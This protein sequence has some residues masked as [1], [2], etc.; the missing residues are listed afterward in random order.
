M[1]R[2]W[3]EN[4]LLGEGGQHSRCKQLCY[5]DQPSE[6]EDVNVQEGEEQPLG[7]PIV[8]CALACASLCGVNH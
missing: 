2:A 5:R 6:D 1:T 4:S 7:A 8:G 3:H